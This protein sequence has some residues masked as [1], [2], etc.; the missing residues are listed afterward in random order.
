MRTTLTQEQWAWLVSEVT[1]AVTV[2]MLIGPVWSSFGAR[3]GY[4]LLSLPA[5]TPV[6]DRWG[7]YTPRHDSSEAFRR[8]VR[9]GVSLLSLR[10]P[11]L[12]DGSRADPTN[13]GSRPQTLVPVRSLFGQS[14]PGRT[15]TLIPPY[16][17][18]RTVKGTVSRPE[19]RT[20]F[21]SEKSSTRGG[22][23]TAE[24]SGCPVSDTNLS[25]GVRRG[26]GVWGRGCV[27]PIVHLGR[28][29]PR[30]WGQLAPVA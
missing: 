25:H 13:G 14:D 30:I 9:V 20:I 6:S 29:A 26:S 12:G 10:G 28:A 7:Q 27:T 22:G 15:K 17:S 21:A 11:C 16:L 4:V 19:G 5:D 23:T 1:G 8:V 18:L 2:V 24:G 3:G